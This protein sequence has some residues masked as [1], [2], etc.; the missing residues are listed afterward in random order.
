MIQKDIVS[1]LEPTKSTNSIGEDL[2]TYT[3][4]LKTFKASAQPYG[5]NEDLRI[6][7]WTGGDAYKV[8]TT[9]K[10]L[11]V[12]ILSS[13]LRINGVEH[14]IINADVFVDKYTKFITEEVVR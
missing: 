4:N 13:H 12:N 14:R 1:I 7:G 3:D 8:F 11:P 10:I 2:L 5:K 6:F 9:S